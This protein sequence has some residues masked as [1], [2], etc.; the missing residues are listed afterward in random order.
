ME[1]E[2]LTEETDPREAKLMQLQQLFRQGQ[3]YGQR[4]QVTLAGFTGESSS[5]LRSSF[6]LFRFTPSLPRLQ[7]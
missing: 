2:D 3:S 5:V 4:V 6:V 7:C 1:E